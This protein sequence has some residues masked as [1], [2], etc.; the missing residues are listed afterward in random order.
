MLHHPFVHIDELLSVDGVA[1]SCY[2]EAFTAC[3]QHHSHPEDYY[4]DP[5]P[6]AE[7]L[8]DGDDEYPDDIE[9]D[10]EVEVPLA[11]FEAYAQ[12]RP[13]YDLGQLDGLDGLGTRHIDR[14]YDW[15]P[16]VGKYS[17]DS[18]DWGRLWAENPIEQAVDVS[19][20]ANCL[21]LE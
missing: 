16:H 1:Y 8:D 19:L 18:E 21:N 5:E 11:D 3:Y 13:N 12:R 4:I 2:Q 20:S 14:A 6:D 7:E 17:L 15:S 9:P 10:P